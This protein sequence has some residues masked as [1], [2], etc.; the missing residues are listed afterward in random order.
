M[1]A[2]MK[3]YQ[4]DPAAPIH[5]RLDLREYPVRPAPDPNWQPMPDHGQESIGLALSFN[6]HTPDLPGIFHPPQ[7]A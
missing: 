7:N 2:A 1:K 3:D 5:S 6:Y 4:G